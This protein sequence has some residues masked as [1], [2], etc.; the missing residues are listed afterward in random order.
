MTIDMYPMLKCKR[1]IILLI[2][3]LPIKT[4]A[5]L[6]S[7]TPPYFTTSLYLFEKKKTEQFE[8]EQA[9]D[10][11]NILKNTFTGGIFENDSE[12][13][14]P[15]IAIAQKIKSVSDLGWTQ[16]GKRP[17]SI[18]PRHR[19]WG[20][21]GEMAIQDKPNYDETGENCAEKWLGMDDFL[22]FTKAKEGPA[23]D[24]VFVAL[25]GGNKFAERDIC[26]AR[27][28]EWTSSSSSSNSRRGAKSFNE[29]AFIKAVKEGRKDLLLGWALFLSVNAFFASSIIFPTNPA[30]KGMEAVI[31]RLINQAG[32]TPV[33]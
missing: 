7:S 1:N 19:A 32:V 8:A 6:R 28:E 15:A 33:G 3:F 18:R 13:L 12:V 31:D 9:K 11:G 2:V 17:G 26:E 22:K 29:A 10:G 5:F 20:G 14:V 30:A 24:T 16:P 23:A 21:E 25:A 4:A 27:I